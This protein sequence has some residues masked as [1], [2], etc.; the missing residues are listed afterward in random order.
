MDSSNS[1]VPATIPLSAL[2]GLKFDNTLGALYIGKSKFLMGIRYVLMLPER[3]SFVRLSAVSP[4]VLR[5]RI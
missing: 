4:E 1:T 5:D 2:Q 3:I